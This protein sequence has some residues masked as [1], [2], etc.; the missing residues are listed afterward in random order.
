MNRWFVG[1]V[2]AGLCVT[3]ATALAASQPAPTPSPMG[4][5]SPTPASTM[6]P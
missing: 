2:L 4:T 1:I 6:L 3:G 5:A